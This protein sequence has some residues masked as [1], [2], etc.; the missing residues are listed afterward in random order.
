[1]QQ[2]TTQTSAQIMAAARQQYAAARQREAYLFRQRVEDAWNLLQQ[3]HG[4]CGK[5][6][7]AALP[8]AQLALATMTAFASLPAPDVA[9]LATPDQG[10]TM[11]SVAEHVAREKRLTIEKS[12]ELTAF[13]AEQSRWGAELNRAQQHAIDQRQAAYDAGAPARLFAKLKQSGIVLGLDA[14]K[15][16]VPA[17]CVLAPEDREAIREN[18]V[19]LVEMVRAE[20]AAARPLVVA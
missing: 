13:Y 6:E 12:P 2:P 10:W 16:T 15:L 7:S 1:M 20:I 18:K 4:T 3:W 5:E 11:Q 17:G 9:K 14:G 19:A 8:K